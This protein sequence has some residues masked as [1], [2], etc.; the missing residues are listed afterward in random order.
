M[1]DTKQI[2]N[3]YQITKKLGLFGFENFTYG[4]IIKKLHHDFGFKINLS[5]D[6]LGERDILWMNVYRNKE[7]H[8]NDK[9]NFI[10]YASALDFYFKMAVN[11]L[12]NEKADSNVI[13]LFNNESIIK[14]IDGKKYFSHGYVSDDL[15]E[16]FSNGSIDKICYLTLLDEIKIHID[17]EKYAIIYLMYDERTNV[18][19]VTKI[20]DLFT[21]NSFKHIGFFGSIVEID[22]KTFNQLNQFNLVKHYFGWL[23]FQIDKSLNLI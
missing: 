22:L 14:Y 5:N 23:P 17:D 21:T 3:D 15:S 12:I 13:E 2:Y 4:G 10:S 9:F 1:F 6:F 19:Y 8:I 7:S 16:D 11:I 20:G 18:K